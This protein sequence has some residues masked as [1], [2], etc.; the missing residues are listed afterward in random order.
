MIAIGL[1]LG[2]QRAAVS[3]G[4]SNMCT[5]AAPAAT[6][7]V[8]TATT[9]SG[10]VSAGCTGVTVYSDQGELGVGVVDG[11]TWSYSWT[12]GAPAEGDRTLHAVATFAAGAP[13]TSES[14]ATEPNALLDHQALGVLRAL[15]RPDRGITVDG[16]AVTAWTDQVASYVL[17]QA[18]P[19]AQMTYAP[20]GWAGKPCLTCAGAQYMVCT[21]DDWNTFFGGDDANCVL[22][23]AHNCAV[24]NSEPLGVF[25]VNT[26]NRIFVWL[27]AAGAQV[28]YYR[29]SVGLTGATNS[30]GS[31]NRHHVA[32]NIATASELYLNGASVGSGTVN[33]AAMT[34]THVALGAQV[35]SYIDSYATGNIGPV[36]LYSTLTNPSALTELWNA[37]GWAH[38]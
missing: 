32:R 17:A 35:L 36:A 5:L 7:P 6:I 34:L 13:A 12:P 33:A 38:S 28:R 18:T 30:G 25:G 31:G 2:T 10:T 19:G 37:L 15:W 1:R 20:T 11:E 8:L 4:A 21:H 26:N 29:A 22:A 27:V 23:L 9:L 24:G 14:R 3:S 16:S